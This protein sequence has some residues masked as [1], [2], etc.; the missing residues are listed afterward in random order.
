MTLEDELR[1]RFIGGF[2]DVSPV[3]DTVLVISDRFRDSPKEARA[4]MLPPAVQQQSGRVRFVLLTPEEVRAG[5]GNEPER[6]LSARRTLLPKDTNPHG[7]IFGGVILSEID[8]AGAAEAQ[9]HTDH[10]V[11]TKYM[12][13]ISFD[14]PVC[15]GDTVS[16]YTTLVKK[17]TTSLTIKVEVEVNRRDEPVPVAVVATEVVY[18]A[19]ERDG[20]GAFH[21]VPV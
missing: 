20:T 13:G 8:L 15:V 1:A 21:R 10:R 12:N 4:L 5:A 17:G 6:H 16:F 2:V 19:V 18:V 3:S 9:R 14:H 11:V 7:Y